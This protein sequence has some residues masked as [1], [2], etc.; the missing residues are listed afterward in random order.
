MTNMAKLP[1]PVA[2]N[3]QWQAR[4]ACRGLDVMIFFHPDH[5]RGPSRRRREEQ[6]KAICAHCPVQRA[7]LDWALSIGELHGVWGGT[8]ASE[9]V[10]LLEPS[11]RRA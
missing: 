4:A 5:E 6:A 1:K 2:E 11:R 8:S 10:Q 3:W 9:R 7:C